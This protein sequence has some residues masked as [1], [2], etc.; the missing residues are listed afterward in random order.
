MTIH[1]IPEGFAAA[2]PLLRTGIG[3]GTAVGVAALTGFV[4]PPMAVLA[5]AA[6][7]L[8]SALLPLGLSFAAGAMLFVIIDELIPESHA[9]GNERAASIALVAGFALM[10][11]LDNGF[12]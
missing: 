3:V 1:N 12:G 2:A 7:D 11:T 5:Y 10:L 9:R 8:V 4:E 6:L